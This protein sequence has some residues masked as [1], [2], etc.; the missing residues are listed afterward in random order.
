[1]FKSIISISSI[2]LYLVGCQE[3]GTGATCREVY[4]TTG[5]QAVYDSVYDWSSADGWTAESATFIYFVDTTT[6]CD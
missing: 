5:S 2:T 3:S 6:V 1:M 4:D